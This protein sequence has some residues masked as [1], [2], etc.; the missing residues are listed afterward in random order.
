MDVV[1]IEERIER[2]NKSWYPETEESEEQEE[3]SVD[4]VNEE[5]ITV[6]LQEAQSNIVLKLESK[7]IKMKKVLFATSRMS[8]F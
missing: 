4:K 2:R 8:R 3:Q 7:N 1:H 5:K 6:V